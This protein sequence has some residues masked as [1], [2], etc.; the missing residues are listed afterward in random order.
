MRLLGARQKQ[1]PSDVGRRER[2]HVRRIGERGEAGDADDHAEVLGVASVR[3]GAVGGDRID[4][5]SVR[6]AT[7][8][9]HHRTRTRRVVDVLADAGPATPWEVAAE[10]FGTLSEIHILH[11]PDE[12]FARF[13]HLA[14]AGVTERD[15]SRCRLVDPG[16]DVG[17]C[18]RRPASNGRYPAPTTSDRR[19]PTESD[20]SGVLYDTS[21]T[22][23]PSGGVLCGDEFYRICPH[24]TDTA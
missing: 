24:G 10:L 12:A 16:V 6:A 17:S 2:G 20:R 21:K 1:H 23:I 5:P 14:A 22:I 8:L 11:G 7:I 15:G 4:E 3:V 19:R 18:S 13:D 9:D